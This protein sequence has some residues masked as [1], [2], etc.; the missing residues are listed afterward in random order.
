[1]HSQ[2]NISPNASPR[3]LFFSITLEGIKTVDKNSARFIPTQS[4]YED[5]MSI[6]WKYKWTDFWW[7]YVERMVYQ[8]FNIDTTNLFTW[9]EKS[10]KDI[11]KR[12]PD[13]A[14]S[15]FSSSWCRW[16]SFQS[17]W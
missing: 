16:L 13:L 8:P 11:L 5:G 4:W 14:S 10:R 2:N 3:L 6:L 17:F 15:V 7:R 12:N 1:M 9:D